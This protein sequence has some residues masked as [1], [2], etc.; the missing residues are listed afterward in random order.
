MEQKK[1]DIKFG[2]KTFSLSVPFTLGQLRVFQPAFLKFAGRFETTQQYD[3]LFEAIM[4]ALARDYPST[5][6]EELLAT[7]ITPEELRDASD[8]FALASGLFKKE[9]FDIAVKAREASKGEVQ[10]SIGASSTAN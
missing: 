8:Q 9:Q 1:T 2:A 5:T 6:K 4:A 10:A 7:E 3:A